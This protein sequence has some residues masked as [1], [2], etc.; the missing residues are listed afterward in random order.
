MQRR[1]YRV[2]LEQGPSGS[3]TTIDNRVGEGQGEVAAT[4]CINYHLVLC[5]VPARVNSN[6]DVTVE[7]YL[8]VQQVPKA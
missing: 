1:K 3:M 8:Y 2:L 5:C 4:Y 7:L 6:E